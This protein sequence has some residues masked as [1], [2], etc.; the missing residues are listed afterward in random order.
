MHLHELE[1]AVKLRQDLES[2]LQQVRKDIDYLN[3][4]LAENEL[5]PSDNLELASSKISVINDVA[6]PHVDEL[7]RRRSQLLDE[8]APRVLA[9]YHDNDAELAKS[10]DDLRS[11]LDTAEENYGR[12][13]RRVDEVSENADKLRNLFAI[14]TPVVHETRQCI[15]SCSDDFATKEITVEEKK[16]KLDELREASAKLASVNPEVEEVHKVVE[17]QSLL[18]HSR[19]EAQRLVDQWRR[20]SQE[21]EVSYSSF[22][23]FWRGEPIRYQKSLQADKQALCFKLVSRY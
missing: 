22:L 18:D 3:H 23:D 9:L 12:S 17:S 5:A 21:T 10:L 2:G 15:N 7:R 8:T 20:L 6:P 1:E 11:Q 14:I 16:R 4:L 19:H 13:K